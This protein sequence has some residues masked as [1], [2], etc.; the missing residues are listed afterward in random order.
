V[1]IVVLFEESFRVF[2]LK[3][4]Q[5]TPYSPNPSYNGEG[6][7]QTHI[8]LPWSSLP[9]SLLLLSSSQVS[10]LSD[11][12]EGELEEVLPVLLRLPDMQILGRSTKLQMGDV[13]REGVQPVENVCRI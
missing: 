9:A 11:P 10:V 5:Q 8:S 6:E 12:L 1:G 13:S 3:R 4:Y 7:K 2:R